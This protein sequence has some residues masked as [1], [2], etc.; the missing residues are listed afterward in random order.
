MPK[1]SLKVVLHF[2]RNVSCVG[3]CL[4][5]VEVACD[6]EASALETSGAIAGLYSGEV[7]ISA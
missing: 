2:L 6:T 7:V 5:K 1:I 4:L 3:L